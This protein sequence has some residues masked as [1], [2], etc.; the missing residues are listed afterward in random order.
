MSDRNGVVESPQWGSISTA[1][2]SPLS[3]SREAGFDLRLYFGFFQALA[4]RDEIYYLRW[5]AN[6][7]FR[8]K[9][10]EIIVTTEISRLPLTTK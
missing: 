1:E 5:V 2:D 6:Q 4:D 8:M 9:I 10:G 7:T 3:A